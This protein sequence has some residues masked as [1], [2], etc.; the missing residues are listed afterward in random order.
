MESINVKRIVAIKVI[1]TDDFRKQ[2]VLE[3]EDVMR[4]IETNLKK[5]EEDLNDRRS[6]PEMENDALAGKMELQIEEERIRLKN[7]RN[8]L[9]WRIKMLEDVQN[10][11]EVPY[12]EIEGN[13]SFSVGDDFLK[14]MSRAEIVIKDWKVVEIRQ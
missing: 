7:M 2:L 10:G 4:R 9:N 6:S 14:K 1:M 5:M 3:A 8:E 11:T 13:V 12:R